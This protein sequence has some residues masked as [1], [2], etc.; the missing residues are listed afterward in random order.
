MSLVQKSDFCTELCCSAERHFARLWSGTRGE[1]R[2]STVMFPEYQMRRQ[3]P[4]EEASWLLLPTSDVNM[5][6][7]RRVGKEKKKFGAQ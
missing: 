7:Y 6:R 1:V 4:A 3:C 2:Q 5:N